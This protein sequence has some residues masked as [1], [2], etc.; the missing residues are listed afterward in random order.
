MERDLSR[1]ELKGFVEKAG[2]V[3]DDEQDENR[4]LDIVI[5][6]LELRVGKSIS[7]HC[8]HQELEEFEALSDVTEQKQWLEKHVPQY[9]TIVRRHGI[10]IKSEIHDYTDYINEQKRKRSEPDG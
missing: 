9:K 3:F 2:I 10:K 4:F 6:D 7:S 8:T 1:S 5:A